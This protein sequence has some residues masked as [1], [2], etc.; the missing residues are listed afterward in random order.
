MQIAMN[1]L[2]ADHIGVRDLKTNLSKR[3]KNHRPL[4]VTDHSQPVKVIL[5]YADMLD[6][7][8]MLD[9]L[10]DPRTVKA[11]QDG[12][13]AIAAGAKGIPVSKT[14]AKWRKSNGIV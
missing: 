11:V 1:L 7:L 10:S 4:V 12:R 8:D 9:E 2:K 13:K 5:D 14:I 3:L 6:L